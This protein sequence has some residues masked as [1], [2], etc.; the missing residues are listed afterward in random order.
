MKQPTPREYE[1][2]DAGVRHVPTDER[3]VPYPGTPAD[4]SWQDGRAK[5]ADEYDRDK[6]RVLG[7]RLWAKYTLGTVKPV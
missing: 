6:V 2:S 7:R 5:G 4:G 3:F 1:I